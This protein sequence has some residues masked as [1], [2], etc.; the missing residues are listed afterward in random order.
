MSD[1]FNNQLAQRV[2]PN[3]AIS[4]LQ[5]RKQVAAE[6]ANGAANLPVA[7]VQMLNNGLGQFWNGQIDPQKLA[8]Q[9]DADFGKG[10]TAKLFELHVKLGAFVAAEAP[11]LAGAIQKRPAGYD[12]TINADG[13]VSITETEE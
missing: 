13:S 6:V 5:R 4:P 8:D 7:I 10:Y 9:L 12:I 3:G 11:A 2:E 1:P